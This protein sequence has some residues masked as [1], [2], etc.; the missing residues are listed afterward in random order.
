MT[1]PVY[2][3]RAWTGE[4]PDYRAMLRRWLGLDCPLPVFEIAVIFDSPVTAEMRA[5]I[6][7][8]YQQEQVHGY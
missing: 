3:S 6:E 5:K 8:L 1:A 4:L 7:R 2:D